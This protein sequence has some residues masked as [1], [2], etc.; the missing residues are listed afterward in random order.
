M[1]LKF[2]VLAMSAVAF[3]L[4]SSLANAWTDHVTVTG[5]NKV[6]KTIN[7]QTIGTEI[8]NKESNFYHDVRGNIELLKFKNDDG[9]FIVVFSQDWRVDSVWG[10]ANYFRKGEVPVYV[11]G[12]SYKLGELNITSRNDK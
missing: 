6:P 5:C 7:C 11:N 10:S 12:K 9:D 2:A 1:R 8:F 3:S 4:S